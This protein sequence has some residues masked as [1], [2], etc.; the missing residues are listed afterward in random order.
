MEIQKDI[1][2][3]RMIEVDIRSDIETIFT[4]ARAAADETVEDEEGLYR[5]QIIF[6]TPGR[7]L[8]GKT[9]PLPA[10]IPAEDLTRLKDLIP[11]KPA[12]NIAAISYTCLEALQIDMAKA[13]PFL[14]YLLGFATLGHNVWVFEGHESA[15]AAGCRDADILLVDEGMLPY[16]PAGWRQIAEKAMRGTDIK[17]IPRAG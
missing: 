1:F 7:L 3:P 10:E 9:C 5:R 15:L 17:Q 6:V 12:V 2:E 13:V 8:L 16:I 14:G 4:R 11:P